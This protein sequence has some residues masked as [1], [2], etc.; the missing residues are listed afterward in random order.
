MSPA[1]NPAPLVTKTSKPAEPKVKRL[2]IKQSMS[3]LLDV[4]VK[5]ATPT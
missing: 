1:E 4:I 3:G 5:V 2:E